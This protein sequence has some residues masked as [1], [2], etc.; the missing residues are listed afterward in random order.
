MSPNFLR[1]KSC[2]CWKE[3]RKENHVR[4]I[5]LRLLPNAKRSIHPL[6]SFDNP[7]WACPITGR[8]PPLRSPYRLTRRLETSFRYLVVPTFFECAVDR[9]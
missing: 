4:F 9:F 1:R 3:T 5:I 7:D 6:L 2:G 8:P